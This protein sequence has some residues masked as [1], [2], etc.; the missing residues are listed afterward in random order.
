MTSTVSSKYLPGILIGY[1]KDLHT[2]ASRLTRSGTLIPAAD[3]GTLQEVL[4]V[5]ELKSEFREHTEDDV[6]EESEAGSVPDGT[7]ETAESTGESSGA[8]NTESS[9]DSGEGLTETE[10]QTEAETEAQTEA[11]AVTEA[12]TEESTDSVVYVERGPDT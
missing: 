1:A 9:A 11:P 5:T 2:D 10:T 3:F 6:Y 8:E 7:D 4:V 12:Q